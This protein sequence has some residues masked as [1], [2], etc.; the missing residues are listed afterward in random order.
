MTCEELA[1]LYELYTLDVLEDRERDEIAAHLD[2]GC[3]TCRKG[4]REALVMNAAMLNTSPDAVP[5]ARL[6]RR[7]MAAV[8]AGSERRSPWGW[9]AA[10]AAA[11]MLLF[12]VRTTLEKRQGDLELADARKAIEQSHAERERM[13][14]ALTFLNQP[15]TQQVGFG[16]DKP[17]RGNIF[18]NPS[19]GILLIASNL[20]P[21]T[22]GH[23]FEMWVIPKGGAPRPAG[24]FQSAASGTAFHM[25]TAA[26]VNSGDA[27]AVTVEPESGS[28][29]PTTTPL[30]V[31]A[32]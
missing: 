5:P 1:D 8:G 32:I 15:E 31:Q 24:L 9:V 21:L 19:R 20:P 7:V 17:A 28:Q 30:F 25:L 14:Q 22:P 4:V 29:A 27:I 16:K 26:W 10:F 18:V 2:R 11:A 23:I 13:L 3:E 12:A 6:K